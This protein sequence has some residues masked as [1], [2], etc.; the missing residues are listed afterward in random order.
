MRLYEILENNY[1][2]HG[3]EAVRLFKLLEPLMVGV[4]MQHLQA[5]TNDHSLL[6]EVASSLKKKAPQLQDGIDDIIKV[7]GEHLEKHGPQSIPHLLEQVGQEKLHYYS[8]ASVEG[9]EEDV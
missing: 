7:A 8:I 5:E 1:K 4:S 2:R 9:Y 3:N 6:P